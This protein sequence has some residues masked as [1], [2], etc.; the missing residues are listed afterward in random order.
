MAGL[1]HSVISKARNEERRVGYKALIKIA[2]AFKEDRV[3]VLGIGGFMLRKGFP[4]D[5]AAYD[6]Q[7]ERTKDIARRAENLSDE[8]LKMLEQYVDFLEQGEVKVKRE[9]SK[10]VG[11]TSGTNR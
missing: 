8:K 1:A 2:D 9:P 4:N 6:N 5:K 11:A 3:Y 7:S 10:K